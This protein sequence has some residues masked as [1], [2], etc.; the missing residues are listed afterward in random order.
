MVGLVYKFC[1]ICIFCKCS[2]SCTSSFFAYFAYS[3]SAFVAY[4]ACSTYFAY[5]AY[6]HILHFLHICFPLPSC[7][8]LPLKTSRRL[9]FRHEARRQPAGNFEE[10]FGSSAGEKTLEIQEILKRNSVVLLESR[11]SHN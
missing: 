11:G 4:V 8:D 10:K 9:L 2:I 3:Y 7:S 1:M 6:L 5:F